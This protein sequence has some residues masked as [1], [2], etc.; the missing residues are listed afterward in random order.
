MPGA[1][2]LE[3][4]QPI[5]PILFQKIFNYFSFILGGQF[6]LPQKTINYKR[7]LAQPKN[8][9]TFHHRSGSVLLLS[10]V[11]PFNA[12]ICCTIQAY[13]QR[14]P[15]RSQPAAADYAGG[16]HLRFSMAVYCRPILPLS[17]SPD[18]MRQPKPRRDA[19][20]VSGR[21]LP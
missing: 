7:E 1:F 15:T 10:R 21:A 2:K 4:L 5:K 17:L 11:F 19:S 3:H 12:M 9:S 18:P 13:R 6:L 14:T 16:R 8:K 20:P